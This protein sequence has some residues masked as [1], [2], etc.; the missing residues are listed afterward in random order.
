MASFQWDPASLQATLNYPE[1]LFSAFK[2]A[3]SG[4]L[5]RERGPDPRASATTTADSFAM[6]N[7][8]SVRRPFRAPDD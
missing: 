4:A 3:D 5:G 8:R 1:L 2:L 7:Y 6:Q